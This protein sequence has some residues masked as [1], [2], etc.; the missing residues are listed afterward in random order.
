MATALEISSF[1]GKFMQLSSCGFRAD[2]NFNCSDGN[3]SVNLTAELECNIPTPTVPNARKDVKPSQLRR[4][5]RRKQARENTAV[6]V[7]EPDTSSAQ[8]FQDSSLIEDSVPTQPFDETRPFSPPQDS[9]PL[10]DQTSENKH[11]TTSYTQ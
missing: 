8:P 5:Q 6:E 10:I 1:I 4:R 3:V 11:M 9:T 2:L 7:H